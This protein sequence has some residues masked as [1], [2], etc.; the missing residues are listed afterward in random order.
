MLTVEQKQHRETV[1]ADRAIS[2]TRDSLDR[3][4]L[5]GQRVEVSN[6]RVN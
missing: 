6:T 4:S 3:F 5:V 2:N 1:H